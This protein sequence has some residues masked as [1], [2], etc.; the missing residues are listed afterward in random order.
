MHLTSSRN[1]QKTSKK[2]TVFTGLAMIKN[3]GA[4]QRNTSILVYYAGSD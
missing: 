1:N 2:V 3:K 4:L